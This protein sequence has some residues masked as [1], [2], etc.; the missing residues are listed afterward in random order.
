MPDTTPKKHHRTTKKYPLISLEMVSKTYGEDPLDYQ[1]LVLKNIYLEV[2]EG[3]FVVIFGPSGSGKSTILNIMAGLELPTAGRMLIRRHDLSQFS[4]DEIALYHRSRMGMVFQNFNLIKSLNVWENVALPQAASGINYK[5]RKRR[6]Q[7]LLKLLHIDHYADRHPNEISGGEQQRVAIARALINNPYFLLIDEPTGNLDSKSAEDVMQILYDLNYHGQHTIVMVTHNPNQLHYASRVVYV[8]DG[9]IIIE[10]K[11]DRSALEGIQRKSPLDPHEVKKLGA[12]RQGLT[13]KE[14]EQDDEDEPQEKPAAAVSKSSPVTAIPS[15]LAVTQGK[16]PETT[17]VAPNP[18][19]IPL[20]P[21]KKAEATP[22]PA[23]S[24]AAPSAPKITPESFT[25]KVKAV[26]SQPD[27]LPDPKPAAGHSEDTPIKPMPNFKVERDDPSAMHHTYPEVPRAPATPTPVAAT[28]T[29][30]PVAPLP[31]APLPVAPTSPTEPAPPIAPKPQPAAPAP[32]TLT[33]PQAPV[34][35][36][37]P[38][39]TPPIPKTPP[40]AAPESTDPNPMTPHPEPEAT[41]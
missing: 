8:E 11:R 36:T 31:V 10:E 19:L 25:P 29:P 28:P 16:T 3:E 1:T 5:T 21:L 12:F 40:P 35:P 17:A 15:V 20:A 26:E 6:A 38:L 23:P 27:Q 30:A 4:S 18:A 33:E 2:M 13:K 22:T 41:K 37:G 34:Y 32:S 7:R 9:K 24:D 14:G 39:I